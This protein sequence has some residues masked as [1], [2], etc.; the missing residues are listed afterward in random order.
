MAEIIKK[1]SAGTL[2]SSDAFVEVSPGKGTEIELESV[3]LDQ[4]GDAIRALVR[5]TLQ[6][7]GIRD[8]KVRIVDRGA[9]DC[10]L[11]ARLETALQRGKGKDTL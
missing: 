4:F 2:E 7:E 10:V 6:K 11:E 1:A 9:L 8:V 5:A 3:V